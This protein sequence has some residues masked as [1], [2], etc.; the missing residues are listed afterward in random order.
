MAGPGERVWRGPLGEKLT[1][2]QDLVALFGTLDEASTVT[3]GNDTVVKPGWII[4][5]L[6]LV[7]SW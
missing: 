6:L 4:W 5:A 2:G 1:V 7:V 3:V